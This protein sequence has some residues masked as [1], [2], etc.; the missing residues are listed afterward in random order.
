MNLLT[1][2]AGGMKIESAHFEN[3]ELALMGL[4]SDSLSNLIS[5]F[6]FG[7]RDTSKSQFQSI[8]ITVS[9]TVN[10]SYQITLSRLHA[11]TYGGILIDVTPESTGDLKTTFRPDSGKGE[12]T[13]AD[14]FILVTANV[15]KRIPTGQADPAET[16][17]RQPF[18]HPEYA[19]EVINLE[20]YNPNRIPLRALVIGKLTRRADEYIWD[21]D[22]IPPVVCIKSYSLLKQKYNFIAENF[23]VLQISLYNIIYKVVNKGKNIPL[24]FNIKLIAEKVVYP[25]SSFSFTLRHSVPNSSPL[26]LVDILSQI[27]GCLKFSIEFLHEK[28]KEDLLNYF[29]EWS[30]LAPARL[31]ELFTEM[32]EMDYDHHDISYSINVCAEFVK[33]FAELFKRISELDIIGA[34]KS[35]HSLAVRET[36]SKPQKKFRLID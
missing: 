11:I 2:W 18:V 19:L 6:N 27:A 36:S 7:L 30:D 14:F 8:E 9:R 21:K 4:A 13:K 20:S 29:K 10:D 34:R 3:S 16:P 1:N 33:E 26:H 12:S 32:I 35:D 28:E 23:N 31:D 15:N 24:A 5:P 22:Y 25:L 17:A